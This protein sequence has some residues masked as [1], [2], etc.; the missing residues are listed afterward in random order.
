MKKVLF[1]A[2]VAL[3]AMLASC[4]E[5]TTQEK[6]EDSAEEAGKGIKKF[7]KNL[8]DAAEEAAE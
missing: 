6:I 2:I 7:G 1:I 8:K 3:G 4:G 5:K